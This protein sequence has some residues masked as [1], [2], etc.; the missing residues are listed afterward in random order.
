MIHLILSFVLISPSQ[1]WRYLPFPSLPLI[2]FI[3]IRSSFQVLGKQLD[4]SANFFG[5]QGDEKGSITFLRV[6]GAQ[7]RAGREENKMM[8]GRNSIDTGVDG[9]ISI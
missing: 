3:L 8:I 7:F 6:I 5:V 2:L 1:S 4:L 9:S